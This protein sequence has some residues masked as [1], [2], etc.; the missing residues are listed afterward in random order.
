MFISNCYLDVIKIFKLN[1]MANEYATTTS[2]EK[3]QANA[4]DSH[5]CMN[6]RYHEKKKSIEHISVRT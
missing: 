5:L 6:I 1:G 2:T 3:E 4:P